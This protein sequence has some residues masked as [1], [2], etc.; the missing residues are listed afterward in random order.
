[1]LTGRYQ[2]LVPGTV[3]GTS[4]SIAPCQTGTGPSYDSLTFAMTQMSDVDQYTIS[5]HDSSI[6]GIGDTWM[7]G[8]L[9]HIS[10]AFPG[11]ACGLPYFCEEAAHQLLAAADFLL[12]PSRFEPCG[13]VAM[14]GMRY[15]AVPITTSVGGFR[16]IVTPEAGSLAEIITVTRENV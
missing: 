12:L 15:G 3:P 14:H 5:K 6:C 7:E 9:S 2:Q 16:D 10:K 11:R 8:A 4:I 1:M 13:L